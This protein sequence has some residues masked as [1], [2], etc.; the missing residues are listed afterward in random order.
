MK[1]LHTITATPIALGANGQTISMA[2]LV[3]VFKEAKPCIEGAGGKMIFKPTFSDVDFLVH[4][5]ALRG[6]AAKLVEIAGFCEK[7]EWPTF[8]IG[9]EVKPEQN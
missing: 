8:F 1:E 6:V 4:P 2:E 3:L 7:R 5:T 9:K